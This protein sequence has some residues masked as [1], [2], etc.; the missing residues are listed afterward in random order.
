MIY[1]GSALD[2][3]LGPDGEHAL[4]ASVTGDL[5]LWD[6]AT[7]AE[8]RRLVGHTETPFAGV[9]FCPPDGRHALSG[10]GDVFG[11]AEDNTLRL[12]DVT[13]GQEVRRFEGHTDRLWD[14]D[15]SADGRFAVSGSAD[16]TVRLWAIST[17]PV[18]SGVKGLNAGLDGGT[19]TVLADV[20][21]QAV[22]S[23]AISPDG[24]AVLIGP[25]KGAS[26]DPDYSLRLVDR[27]TGAVQRRLSGHT[28]VVADIAFGPSGRRVLSGGQDKLV[29]LWDVETGQEIRRFVGH[30]G[31][32]NR[33]RF[34]PDG[35]FALST[36]LDNLIILWDVETGAT[37]RRYSGHVG[38]VFGVAFTPGGGTFLS[39]ALDDSVREWRIDATQAELLAWVE[40]NRYVSE[41]TCLQRAQY[42]VEPLCEATP[43][44]P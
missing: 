37:L 33:V 31:G 29:I 19:G 10:A 21:P 9:L 14:I 2:V 20:R 1:D 26:N 7:G 25:L 3:A 15:V 42:H 11:I 22:R 13:T 36:G 34:S 40:G 32:V 23:V 35:R 43:T 12:W 44:A 41:L 30:T 5:S 18:L 8:I 16:G 27:E 6:Y 4:L 39:V 24:R 28:D 17:E 38:G